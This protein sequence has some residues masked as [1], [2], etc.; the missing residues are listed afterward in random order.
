MK[1][2]KLA[3]VAIFAAS[4]CLIA[5]FSIPIGPVPITLATFGV[6]LI[7]SFFDTKTSLLIILIYILLGAMGLPVFS[8]YYGGIT[9]IV[10]PT[11]GY[12]IGYIFCV[13]IESLLIKLF[14]NKKWSYPV[15]MFFGTLFIYL[16]GTTWFLFQ[17]N[18]TYTIGKALA[19]CVIPFLPGD[20]IKIVIATM[21]TILCKKRLESVFEPNNKETEGE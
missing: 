6:Y 18:E 1:T 14:K 3:I 10:G 4:L 12:I 7:G 20:S 16:F 11:G 9:R 2:K 21:I 13:I 5:P 8:N 17:M 19:L 15:S